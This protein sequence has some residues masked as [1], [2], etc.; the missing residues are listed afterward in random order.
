M[1]NAL[2]SGSGGIKGMILRRTASR[3]DMADLAAGGKSRQEILE[4]SPFSDEANE[5]A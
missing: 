5:G 1:P 3:V 4:I 2:S